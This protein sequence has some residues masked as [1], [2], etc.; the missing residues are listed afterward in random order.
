[1][2][3]FAVY[4]VGFVAR[5]LGGLFFSHYGDR[6]GRKFV[7]VATLFLMGTATFAIG[8]LPTYEQVGLLSPILLL[9][10]RILQGF[11]AG[12]EQAGG[13][14]LLTETAP[15]TQRGRYAS[16]VYVGAALG[17]VLGALAWIVVLQLLT[18]EQVL[19]W[20]WRVVFLSS[21]V[22]T[23]A[24]Y[25]FRRVLNESPVFEEAKNRG[26]V[27]RE[28]T[29]IA[30]AFKYGWRGIVRVSCSPWEPS[31]T[32]TSSRSSSAPTWSTA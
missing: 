3:S 16:L 23:I 26:E 24:A 15:Q 21:I 1:M 4:G 30:E 25:I 27:G 12:A 6:V 28:K 2:A 32:R 14:V 7:L 18:P 29:P 8:L 19:A 10:C 22:V 11:G 20:G 5:P 13:I 9:L 31:L 17:S